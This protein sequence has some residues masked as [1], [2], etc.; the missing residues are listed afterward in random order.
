[1]SKLHTDRVYWVTGAAS[2]IGRAT[3]EEL[4]REGARVLATDV[5]D[6]DFSWAS[7]DGCLQTLTCDVTQEHSNE[8][9]VA[10]AQ[11]QFGRLDGAVLNAGMAVPVGLLD[12]SLEVFDR[13]MDVNVRGVV[14]G[15][16]AASR[17]LAAGS[18]LSVTASISGIRG[19]PGMWTYNASKGAVLNLVRSLSMELAGLGIRINAVCPGP[20]DTPMTAGFDDASRESLRQSVP[21]KRWG[22]AREVGAAH[23]WLLSTQASY[24]TGISLPVDGGIGANNGQFRPPEYASLGR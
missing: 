3:V 5:E 21:L 10:I 20:I 1:M 17:T 4:L 11:R 22:Q 13:T 12:E 6:A 2:G 8:M 24:I 18:A 7:D 19:D 15:V 16:R 14:L 23:S 9:A